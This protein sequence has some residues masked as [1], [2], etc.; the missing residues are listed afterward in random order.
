MPGR[1]CSPGSM[2]IREVVEFVLIVRVQTMFLD[3]GDLV[4]TG[5]A[6][7]AVT[8]TSKGGV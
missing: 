3:L 6:I 4:N 5:E 1:Q 7:E 8:V 2:P